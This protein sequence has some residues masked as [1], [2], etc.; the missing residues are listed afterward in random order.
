LRAPSFADG[1][2]GIV[3]FADWDDTNNAS[4]W[5]SLRDWLLAKFGREEADQVV[6]GYLVQSLEQ[7]AHAELI[8]GTES[9]SATAPAFAEEDTTM[10]PEQIAAMQAEN[11]RL[12]AEADTL[13]RAQSD[14][15]RAAVHADHVAFAEQLGSEGRLAQG[16]Q[17]LVVTTLDALALADQPIEFGEGDARQPLA[18]ALRGLL[19]AMPKSVEFSELAT[20]AR[21][22]R[23]TGTVDFAA[24]DGASVDQGQLAIHGKVVS[25][26]RA[27]NVTYEAALDAV[28]A[29]R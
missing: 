20:G 7:S 9:D 10:T 17:A 1:E 3:E 15:R 2:A 19:A 23:T 21:A 8:A 4:L 5:R 24:P 22:V 26:Q 16:H 28:L 13:R 14:A 18:T 27:N 25:Y 11:A 29:G 6:P 12:K